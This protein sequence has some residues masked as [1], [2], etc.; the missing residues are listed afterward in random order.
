M[1][2]RPVRQRWPTGRIV[3]GDPVVVLLHGLPVDGRIWDPV[4]QALVEAGLTVLTPDLPGHGH[5]PALARPDLPAFARWL[6]ERLGDLD[7]E[8]LHLVGHDFGGLLAA[9][10]AA[11]RG[12]ASLTLCSTAIGLGWAPV[13]AT[14]LP[15]VERFF[16]RRY[17]GRRWL[18]AGVGPDRRAE[19]LARYEAQ[20]A[21]PAYPERMRRIAAHLPL[22]RC[23]RLPGE[24]RSREIPTLC[25]WGSA[26]RGFPLVGARWTARA[27]QAPLV[28]LPGARH[29][30]MVDA[31]EAF[32]ET[33]VRHVEAG[34]T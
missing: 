6:D 18:A 8:R 17:G 22:R 1:T 34:S 29:Y 12:A 11:R 7:P 33:L 30:A 24:L 14:S 27:L 10:R 23:A 32:A 2:I 26:D 9:D 25:L 3:S 31:A 16:Y 28:V 20:L 13:R 15:G 19:L 5:A 4:A 21:D